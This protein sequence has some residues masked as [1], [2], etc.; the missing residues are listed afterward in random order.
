LGQ[1]SYDSIFY[2]KAMKYQVKEI[3][4]YDGKY[5]IDTNGVVTSYH[6]KKP[7]IL[8]HSWN[9]RKNLKKV[10]LQKKGKPIVAYVHSLMIKT[11]KPIENGGNI[12]FKDGNPENLNINNIYQNKK[13]N[14]KDYRQ[15]YVL[16]KP[17]FYI[18]RMILSA[19]K[20]KTQIPIDRNLITDEL[21]NLY[22]D[23]MNIR[24]KRD[25]LLNFFSK[26]LNIPRKN[27]RKWSSSSIKQI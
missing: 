24:K 21:R 9:G 10:N 20:S 17:D 1:F 26:D 4:G 14:K 3:Q 16:D 12:Y 15:K 13:F 11:F 19:N 18:D 8:T 5:T 23:L 6:F 22:R 2:E 27:I 7:R 25:E